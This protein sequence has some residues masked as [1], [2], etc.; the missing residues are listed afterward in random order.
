MD[1]A[2]LVVT[3]MARMLEVVLAAERDLDGLKALNDTA[4]HAAGDRLL[5]TTARVLT[6]FAGPEQVC[7][8]LGGDE[9]A[10]LLTG[11]DTRAAASRIAA[12]T[13]ALEDAGVRASVGW[14]PLPVGATGVHVQIPVAASIAAAV[15][16][17]DRALYANK[18][19]R[20]RPAAS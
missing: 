16:D 12:L 5:V 9:F 2:G 8:R 19:A 18:A 15:S 17:A 10:V 7:A 6:A 20:R 3:A 14:A 4:G 11:C 1:G 13:G